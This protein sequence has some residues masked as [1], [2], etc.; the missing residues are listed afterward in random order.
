[1]LT[2]DLQF[3][4]PEDLIATRAAEP[5]DAAR[6]MVIDR[7]S[8]EIRHQRVRDLLDLGVFRA[9]D[10]LVLNN[11]RV[12]PAN[13]RGTRTGTGGALQ[14]LF[15][16]SEEDGHWTVMLEAR[17]RLRPGEA[18]T[19]DDADGEPALSLKL[20][21]KI[22]AGNWRVLPDRTV[23]PAELLGRVGSMPLPPYI[24]KARKQ[25]GMAEVDEGDRDRYNTVYADRA[26]SAAAPTAGLHLTPLLL[27]S[28]EAAGVRVARITLHVGL[29]T[30]AP[31]RTERL[32]D[33][34]LHSEWI[35]VTPEA[36]G[37]LET[38]RASGGR[39]LAVGTTSVRT[40]ES[41]PDPLPEEGF[42]GTTDLFIYPGRGFRFRWTDRLMT[43]FHLPGSTLLALV[44]ALPGV[45]T[46]RLL[47]WYGQAIDE[48]Y[49]FYSYGDAMLIL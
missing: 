39:V 49:R 33:H 7:A 17:G 34:T 12:L 23:D 6:L 31:V 21:E 47:D 46:E 26:G 14:G 4:L 32:A 2:A 44:A 3:E 16:N 15:L 11:T 9:G 10:L 24:R 40:L 27:S 5:R 38:T 36:I 48:R 18:W 29:G 20:V 19:I 13:F 1:M 22:D 42:R 43:N 41:L 8:G 25:A 28:L 37:L 45:G 30:F 35:E